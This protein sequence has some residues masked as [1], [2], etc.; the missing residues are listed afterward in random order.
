M[1]SL[2]FILNNINLYILIDTDWD[3]ETENNSVTVHVSALDA[4]GSP[5]ILGTAGGAGG[6][7]L[8]GVFW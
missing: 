3:T 5:E 8:T 2:C 7:S 1:I 4:V 6:D